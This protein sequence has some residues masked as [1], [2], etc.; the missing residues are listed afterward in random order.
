MFYSALPLPL[1]QIS[2]GQDVCKFERK[3]ERCFV[4]PLGVGVLTEVWLQNGSKCGS[5]VSSQKRA[6][7]SI[8]HPSYGLLGFTM[9]LLAGVPLNR[10]ICYYYQI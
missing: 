7:G 4:S 5:L 9:S 6:L 2:E 3:E 1:A 8:K 10:G